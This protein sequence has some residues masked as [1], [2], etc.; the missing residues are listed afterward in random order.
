MAPKTAP[1]YQ[2]T[3]PAHPRQPIG[4]TADIA[5]AR[6]QNGFWC[7]ECKK[8]IYFNEENVKKHLHII[9]NRYI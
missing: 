9:P 5:G 3:C 1:L 4:V 6:F 2:I 8:Y 7:K